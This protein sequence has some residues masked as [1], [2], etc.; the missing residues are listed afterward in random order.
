MY[1]CACVH[2][3]SPQTAPYNE[4]TRQ[5]AYKRLLHELVHYER[6]ECEAILYELEQVGKQLKLIRAEFGTLF[7]LECMREDDVGV[8]VGTR[9]DANCAHRCR[10]S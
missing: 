4:S 6:S 3:L 9:L 1:A 5:P 8:T 2:T 7:K 10:R